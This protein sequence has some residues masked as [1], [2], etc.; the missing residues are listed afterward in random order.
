[1][2]ATQRQPSGSK[3]HLVESG[4]R[5]PDGTCECL[6]GKKGGG[7]QLCVFA[8]CRISR[9]RMWSRR[10][11]NVTPK[12]LRFANATPGNLL[13]MTCRMPVMFDSHLTT[14]SISLSVRLSLSVSVYQSVHPSACISGCNRL[15]YC[16]LVAT[17]YVLGAWMFS[18]NSCFNRWCWLGIPSLQHVYMQLMSLPFCL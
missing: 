7:R 9:W 16:S 11:C 14:T 6:F 1:V 12:E 10:Q 2:A 8:A 3:S 5:W 15:S 13:T 4:Q 18:L 17:F